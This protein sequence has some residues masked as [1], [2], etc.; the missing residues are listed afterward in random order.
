MITWYGPGTGPSCQTMWC[1]SW[2]ACASHRST[3]HMHQVNTLQQ[4]L[5]WKACCMALQMYVQRDVQLWCGICIWLC[6]GCPKCARV[7]DERGQ[8]KKGLERI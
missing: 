3:F 1:T 7:C 6:M 5:K 2:I 8:F 4:Q